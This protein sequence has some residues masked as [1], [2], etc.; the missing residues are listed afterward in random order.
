VVT[1]DR[2]LSSQK[3]GDSMPIVDPELHHRWKKNLKNWRASSLNGAAWCRQ[4]GVTY[5]VF[6]YWK[7]KFESE[8]SAAQPSEEFIEIPDNPAC[9][10]G[11]TL[12]C[13]SVKI[14]LTRGFDHGILE[15]CLQVI[16]R[17]GC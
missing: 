10:S 4:E 11:L 6:H 7:K 13:Q 8:S 9:E 12:E 16:R 5:R 2:V 14:Y 3:Q 1:G 17:L 15:N